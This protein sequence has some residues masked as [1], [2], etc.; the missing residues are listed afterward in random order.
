M[1]LDLDGLERIGK[2]TSQPWYFHAMVD[3]IRRLQKESDYYRGAFLQR[4]NGD[5]PKPKFVPS[6]ILLTQRIAGDW[7]VG[8]DSQAGPG[9]IPCE[10]NQYGAVSVKAENGKMLGVK[11]HEFTVVE[12]KPNSKV[13]SDR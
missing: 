11:L 3:E 10:C 8:H 5:W 4:G 6:K 2:E 1:T 12:W 7:P 9:E 13:A